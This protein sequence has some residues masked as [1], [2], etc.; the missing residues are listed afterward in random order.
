MCGHLGTEAVH[1]LG[2]ICV[3]CVSLRVHWV[4]L[5]N[6]LPREM[7]ESPTLEMSKK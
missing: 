6:R 7:V 1:T 2:I 4:K 5:W 3:S